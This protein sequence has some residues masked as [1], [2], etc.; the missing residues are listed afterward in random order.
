M[1]ALLFAPAPPAW[2]VWLCD[3]EPYI[4]FKC[5]TVWVK[6][7]LPAP[8]L[9]V[10]KLFKWFKW[11]DDGCWFWW[12]NWPPLII[13]DSA[14]GSLAKLL[15]LPLPELLLLETRFEAESLL[16]L[17]LDYG[18]S[19]TGDISGSYFYSLELIKILFSSIFIELFPSI[20][21]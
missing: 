7:E 8:S 20:D 10:D 13:E 16:L 14:F 15:L 6:L 2:L 19:I 12:L 17:F 18:G 11:F 4:G 9:P 21:F 5:V 1:T 3:Y